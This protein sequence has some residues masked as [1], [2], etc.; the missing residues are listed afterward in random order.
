MMQ[1]LVLMSK[2]TPI[3][4]VIN[5]TVEPLLPERLPLFLQR[6]GDIRAWLEARAVDSHRTN[7]RLLK[8]ALRLEH[9]DDLSTVLAVNAATVTDNYWVKPLGDT[10]THYADVRFQVNCFDNL[11]LTG[12]VNSFDQPPGRTPE[13]TNTGSF[14]K[15]WRRRGGEWWMV[16][17][18][19]PEELFS[20]LLAYRLGVA[21]GFPMAE[22]EPDGAFIRSR[23]F[24]RDAQVDFEPAAGIIGDESDYV[25][26]YEAL[27]RFGGTVAGQYVLMCY[28]DALIYNMDRH[29]QNF[30]VLRDSDTGQVLS[31][32]PFF[33]HNIAL[34][35]RGYPRNA[36][37]PNDLLITGFT[38]LAHHAGLPLEIRRLKQG[39]IN[40][41][42]RM[43]PFVPP[44][45]EAVANP[46]AFTVSYLLRR[47]ERLEELNR[48]VLCFVKPVWSR[49]PAR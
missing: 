19:K 35:A 20:E 37:A 34:I 39:A 10:T 42:V 30:G 32:A 29:E 9:K 26:I 17:A 40:T 6:S 12:D 1:D 41:A 25:K 47:Q 2:D 4:R 24:T 14:E 18:G 49:E 11:A 7:S 23:D 36:D 3:A 48:D 8:K 21:L 33:D 45:S 16:K 13:L 38:A 22:Y 31:L 28:F 43:N 44:R 15:C 5:N 27:R 46:L